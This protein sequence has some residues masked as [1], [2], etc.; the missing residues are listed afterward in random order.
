MG[1]AEQ[2]LQG[3]G[4]G[5]WALLALEQEARSRMQGSA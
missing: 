3:L 5:A 4:V 2:W 1:W